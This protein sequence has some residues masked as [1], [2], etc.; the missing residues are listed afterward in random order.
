MTAPSELIAGAETV[1]VG[2]SMIAK[3]P[4]RPIC[5]PP[6]GWN[7]ENWHLVRLEAIE[8][9]VAETSKKNNLLS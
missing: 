7:T 3:L 1:T 6:E 5:Q 9:L 2:G 8:D 4:P